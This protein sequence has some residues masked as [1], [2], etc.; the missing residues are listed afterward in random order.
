M[1]H[2]SG[3]WK[4]LIVPVVGLGTSSAAPSPQAFLTSL[5]GYGFQRDDYLF[6]CFEIQ[7]DYNEGS[8]LRIHI[9][10]APSSTNTG[11]VVWHFDYSYANVD[12]VMP[13]AARLTVIQ[14]GA[15][16]ADT[17][18]LAE[19]AP[20]ISG[21]NRKIGCIVPFRLTRGSAGDGDTYTAAAIALNI[22]VHYECDSLGSNQLYIKD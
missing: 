8:D 15:G 11:D 12:D 19:F 22:G 3:R 2:Y 18:Q 5:S 6:G 13:A 16:A 17:H 21:A 20:V 14:A 9:H 10:W 7:H 4:D 1:S